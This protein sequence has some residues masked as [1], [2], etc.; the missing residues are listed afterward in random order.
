MARENVKC[1]AVTTMHDLNRRA[2]F[3]GAHGSLPSGNDG[4][5]ERF[6]ALGTTQFST[7]PDAQGSTHLFLDL[8][9]H[10]DGLF[11]AT[12]PKSRL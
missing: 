9:A 4:Q 10:V 8:G 12:G 2:L 1:G 7:E 3:R 11:A 5:D 6:A